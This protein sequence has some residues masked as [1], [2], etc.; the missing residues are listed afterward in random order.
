[1]GDHTLLILW[2]RPGKGGK[3]LCNGRGYTRGKGGEKDN[4][5]GGQKKGGKTGGN[6]FGGGTPI[7]LP[8]QREAPGKD[9]NSAL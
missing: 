6:V 7:G 3:R 1:V 5:G 4:K 9:L 8:T 2:G